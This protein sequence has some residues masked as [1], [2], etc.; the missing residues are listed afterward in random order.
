MA[1]KSVWEQALKVHKMR[2]VYSNRLKFSGSS[3]SMNALPGKNFRKTE[4]L[5]DLMSQTFIALNVPLIITFQVP[6]PKSLQY[7]DHKKLSVL[8]LRYDP[9]IRWVIGLCVIMVPFFFYL[10]ESTKHLRNVYFLQE[11]NAIL[12][13]LYKNTYF[14]L[15]YLKNFNLL[16][17]IYFRAKIFLT[18]SWTKY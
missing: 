14:S 9:Q 1:A 13:L 4:G 7:C 8:P 15:D 5:H 2:M 6:L 17:K 12:V 10:F 3:S 11:M 18:T 16:S